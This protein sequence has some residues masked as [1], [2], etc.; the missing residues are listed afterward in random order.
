MPRNRDSHSIILERTAFGGVRS[1]VN[2]APPSPSPDDLSHHSDWI[3][4]LAY[5]ILRDRALAE[6]VSQ[7]VLLRSL[8]G[9]RRQGRVLTAWLR[10]VTTN[11]S[12]KKLR[13]RTRRRQ[14]EMASAR[15]EASVDGPSDAEVLEAHL[16]LTRALQA[17]PEKQQRVVILRFHNGLSFRV[18]GKELGI[19]EGTARTRLHRALETLRRRLSGGGA[20]WRALCLVLAPAGQRA[21]P[22]GGVA[23]KTAAVVVA[24]LLVL[25][26]RLL[27]TGVLGAGVRRRGRNRGPGACTP[28]RPRT[29][30]L[31]AVER[32]ETEAPPA[33][34]TGHQ[35]RT[36]PSRPAWGSR[37]RSPRIRPSRRDSGPGMPRS[38]ST[39]RIVVLG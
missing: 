30:D 39:T 34:G 11:L 8:S 7:E 4:G 19:P 31:P 10:A 32:Q 3:Q 23:L 1:P 29:P 13:E 21:L 35:P 15:P 22:V 12:L 36:D 24:A 18:I 28:P 5:A 33:G 6:D 38:W 17:L 14:R 26:R 2:P 16:A 9:E 27:A 20:D 37:P 25:V